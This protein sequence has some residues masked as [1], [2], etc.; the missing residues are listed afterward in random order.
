MAATEPLPGPAVI[1]ETE[2]P[3][4]MQAVVYSKYGG[5]EMLEV[6]EVDRPTPAEDEVLVR[7]QSASVNAGDWHLLRGSPF[8]VR[9]IY[10][11][12]RRPS[13]P[14]LGVDIAGEIAAVGDAVADVAVGDEIIADLSTSGFGGFAEYVCVPD[15]MVVTKPASVSS[16]AAAT[17]PTAGVAALQALRDVGGLRAGESVLVNGA[18]GGVGTFAVQIAKSLGANVTGV[19]STGKMDVVRSLGADDV[20]DYTEEDFTE[21]GNRYDLIVDTAGSHSIRAV[22]RAL[23]PGGRYVMVGGP[24][25]RFLGAMV[26]GP[27]VSMF[28]PETV[29]AFT[30]QPNRDDLAVVRDLLESGEVTPVIDRTYP[31]ADV[32][33]AIR[34]LEDGRA[35]GKVGVSYPT[36]NSI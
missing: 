21:S 23:T 34:Y 28:G 17:I 3:S 4:T 20:I 16:E 1:E 26:V 7:V 9:L 30:I 13:I 14:I 22:R 29:R 6:A 27:F 10:G 31:L 2:L 33:E 15:S 8:L 12:I 25:R 35:V 11:G 19:C 24:F 36:T 5:P 18:S 32:A